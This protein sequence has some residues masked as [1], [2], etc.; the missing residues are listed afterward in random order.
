MSRQVRYPFQ[1]ME[2]GDSFLIP[3]GDK[4]PESIIQLV[5]QAARQRGFKIVSRRTDTGVRVWLKGSSN[6]Q[7]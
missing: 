2:P 5:S 4:T 1:R 7:N 6:V 3:Y